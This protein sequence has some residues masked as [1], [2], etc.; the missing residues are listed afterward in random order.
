MNRE[1]RAAGDLCVGDDSAGVSLGKTS[2][3]CSASPLSWR[4]SLGQERE[5]SALL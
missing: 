5:T 4:R 1:R 2:H 3:T